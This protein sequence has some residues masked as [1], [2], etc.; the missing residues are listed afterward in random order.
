MTDGPDRTGPDRTDR[1]GPDG[2]A[3]GLDG[4]LTEEWALGS[5]PVRVGERA[6]RPWRSAF[7]ALLAERLP[8]RRSR[9]CHPPPGYPTRCRRHAL[10]CRAPRRLGPSPPGTADAEVLHRVPSVASSSL[11]RRLLHPTPALAFCRHARARCTSCPAMEAA[12]ACWPAVADRAPG[13][14]GAPWMVHHSPLSSHP[15]AQA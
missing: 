14:A 11:P 1:T 6:M 10:R 2:R 3:G 8:T 12:R 7:Y 15:L 13:W 5:P 4:G 9:C